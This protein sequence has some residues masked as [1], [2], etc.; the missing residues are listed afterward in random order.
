MIHTSAL[1][2]V[3]LRMAIHRTEEPR[4]YQ[5]GFDFLNK[6]KKN[7]NREWFNAHKAEFQKELHLVEVF[8]DALLADLNVHDVIET[9]SGNAPIF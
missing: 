4:I 7:N 2:M 5:S 1:R 8:S 9:P 3:Y 6:L